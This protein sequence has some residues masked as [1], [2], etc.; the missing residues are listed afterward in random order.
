MED[1]EVRHRSVDH[2]SHGAGSGHTSHLIDM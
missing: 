2:V 1:D